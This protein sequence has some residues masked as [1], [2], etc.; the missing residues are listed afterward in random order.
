MSSPAEFFIIDEKLM[1]SCPIGVR[2]EFDCTLQQKSKQ[3]SGDAV[4]ERPINALLASIKAGRDAAATGPLVANCWSNSYNLE[5]IEAVYSAF[6][7]PLP[8]ERTKARLIETLVESVIPFITWDAFDV[9][10]ATIITHEE[11]GTEAPE[12][13][14][15]EIEAAFEARTGFKRARDPP[16]RKRRPSR[17]YSLPDAPPDV[18]DPIEGSC[19]I[20][21]CLG[22]VHIACPTCRATVCSDHVDGSPCCAL[23]DE[24]E[25]A[26]E[27]DKKGARAK[28]REVQ[29]QLSRTLKG[30]ASDLT[31]SLLTG[32]KG[33][34]NSGN[35]AHPGPAPPLLTVHD[36]FLLNQKELIAQREFVDPSVL[37]A[38]RLE[39]LARLP[40]KLDQSSNSLGNGITVTVGKTEASV[41]VKRDLPSFL[42][43]FKCYITLLSQ[44][45]ALSHLVADRLSFLNWIEHSCHLPADRKLEL[46]LQFMLDNKGAD[47]WND[48]ILTSGLKHMAIMMMDQGQG[49]DSPPDRNTR[50]KLEV[51]KAKGLGQTKQVLKSNSKKVPAASTRKVCLTREQ[52]MGAKPCRFGA[53]CKFSHVCP[54]AYCSGADHSFHDCTDPNK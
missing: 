23:V 18:D 51:K 43:G 29:S 10:V 6:I 35:P 33:H 49:C 7:G 15:D 54:R 47:N 27:L 31:Q 46:A 25:D 17:G 40:R 53:K 44:I 2:S 20:A 9:L 41:P 48:L 42:S 39:A 4:L 11:E 52:D 21:G 50:R 14:W 12:L 13:K 32:L 8:E 3:K 37:S 26:D 1:E 19:V 30:F 45:S 38:D 5:G 24:I 22:E 34:L 36:Q 16:K 28:G